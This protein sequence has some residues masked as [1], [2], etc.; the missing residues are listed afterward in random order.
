MIVFEPSGLRIS[1]TYIRPESVLSIGLF[2]KVHV[3]KVIQIGNAAGE[4]TKALL[5][6]TETRHLMQQLVTNIHYKELA[7]HEIF[8]P[9][10]IESLKF[11]K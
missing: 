3:D 10:Y 6:S 5:L 7:N 9:I 11:T 8:Q 1:G 2:P 4:G